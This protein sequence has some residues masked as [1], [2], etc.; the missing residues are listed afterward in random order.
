MVIS[1]I[2]PVYNGQDTLRQCLEM[3]YKSEAVE[4]ECIVV[5]DGSKDG[6]LAVLESFPVKLV[7]IE[8]GP[9]GPANAR[10][11]GAEVANG[12]ILF[13]LDADVLIKPDTLSKIA[14]TFAECPEVDALFGSYDET[15]AKADFLSQYK[16]LLHHYVHQQGHENASTFWSGCGAVRKDVFTKVGGFDASLYPHPSIEDIE[17]GSRLKQ[18][19]HQILLKKDVQVK[20]LKRWSLMGLIKTDVLY[21]A[22][23]WTLLILQGR[24]L[25]NDLNLKFSQRLSSILLV[26]LVLHLALFAFQSNVLLLPLLIALFLLL[27]SGWQWQLGDNVFSMDRG[28][29]Q[30]T[31]GFMGVIGITALIANQAQLLV[32]FVVLLPMLLFG[33]SVAD[34][35]RPMRMAYFW[36][37]MILIAAEFILLMV[38]FPIL[39]ILPFA[40]IVL[41][42]FL[43]NRDLYMFFARKRGVVFALAALPLQLM[44]YLYSL[45]TFIVGSGIYFFQN[46]QKARQA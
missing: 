8:G 15:P 40:T 37:M 27:V 26:L 10:N 4:F 20:H 17:L 44:Y 41:L 7:Q 18:H 1:V 16:N 30:M 2:V 28:L 19:N 22:L 35:S 3:V 14:A 6:T 45:T 9:L 42:I 34:W 43:L 31:F 13:F 46:G 25:P 11:R 5:D 38:N 12:E 39:F 29:E 36:G 33:R 21:R 23:P 32:P 24:T